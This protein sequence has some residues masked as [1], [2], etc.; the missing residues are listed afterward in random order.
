[1]MF[2]KYLRIPFIKIEEKNWETPLAWLEI[3]P[4][5]AQPQP[6]YFGGLGVTFLTTAID[7]HCPLSMAYKELRIGTIAFAWLFRLQLFGDGLPVS[8]LTSTGGRTATL[9]FSQ[10]YQLILL[11]SFA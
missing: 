7:L 1:M 4:C 2:W 9:P 3:I 8:L 6:S 5:Q 11:M 10:L